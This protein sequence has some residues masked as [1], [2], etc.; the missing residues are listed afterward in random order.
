MHARFGPGHFPARG[1]WASLRKRSASKKRGTHE[2]TVRWASQRGS[3]GSLASVRHAHASTVRLIFVILSAMLSSFAIGLPAFLFFW[4]WVFPLALLT[5]SLSL[6]LVCLLPAPQSPF[7][8]R[9]SPGL[10]SLRRRC[11]P[12]RRM[13]AGGC[14]RPQA[15]PNP[16]PDRNFPSCS[17]G[18]GSTE[19]VGVKPGGR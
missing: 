17:R 19:S 3:S 2:S 12:L 7:P 15:G 8:R 5:P 13:L 6:P 18:V 11:A 10:A 4:L 1:L 16:L 14:P 9:A